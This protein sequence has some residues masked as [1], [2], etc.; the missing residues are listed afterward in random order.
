M[1]F[2]PVSALSK[3]HCILV[4]KRINS[5]WHLEVELDSRVFQEFVPAFVI[6]YFYHKNYFR[7]P[8]ACYLPM[9]AGFHCNIKNFIFMLVI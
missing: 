7:A 6:I 9:K 5:G 8:V 1:I 4:D 3:P 2:P